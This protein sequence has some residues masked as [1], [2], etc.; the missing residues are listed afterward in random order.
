MT[1]R[2][3]REAMD[4]A[5]G[6]RIASGDTSVVRDIAKVYAGPLRKRLRRDL[7]D[8]DDDDIESVIHDSLF[9]VFRKYDPARGASVRTFL[10][11]VARGHAGRRLRVRRVETRFGRISSLDALPEAC[12]AAVPAPDQALLDEELW[13]AVDEA[14]R[15]KMTDRERL[16]FRARFGPKVA[17]GWA[18]QLAKAHGGT[19]QSWR[20]ASDDAKQKLRLHLESKGYGFAARG[21]N[22]ELESMPATA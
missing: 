1:H 15:D 6:R 19:A 2:P 11:M 3:E 8:F 18:E 10:F 20:K 22:D 9:D 7:S 5:L 13:E 16:A 4:A 14:C 12:A 21:G 17:M